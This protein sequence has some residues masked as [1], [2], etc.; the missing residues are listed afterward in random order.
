LKVTGP[1]LLARVG[2]SLRQFVEHFQARRKCRSR[3]GLAAAGTVRNAV[4][5][6]RF[7]GTSRAW[8]L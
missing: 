3:T 6:L 1:V 5:A 7:D 8:P 4:T 2:W